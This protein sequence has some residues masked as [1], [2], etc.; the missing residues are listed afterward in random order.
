MRAA[1]NIKNRAV[2]HPVNKAQ[3]ISYA[4]AGVPE[5]LTPTEYSMV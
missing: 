1:I 4:M 2:E 3:L 5:K